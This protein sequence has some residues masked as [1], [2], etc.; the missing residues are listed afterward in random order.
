MLR[1]KKHAS[2]H[3]DGELKRFMKTLNQEGIDFPADPKKASERFEKKNP[4]Y[5]INV[6][7]YDEDEKDENE[8]LSIQRISD[9]M[10][11][12]KNKIID[13]LLYSNGETNHYV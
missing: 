11:E 1:R 3:D 5:A 9:K 2:T 8:R 13:L 6:Y 12:T 7:G 4:G 10:C